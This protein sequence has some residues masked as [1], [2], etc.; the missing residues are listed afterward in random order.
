MQLS[1]QAVE[2][3]VRHP[4]ARVLQLLLAIYA[5]AYVATEHLEV[6]AHGNGSTGIAAHLFPNSYLLHTSILYLPGIFFALACSGIDRS[7]PLKVATFAF[8]TTILHYFLSTGWWELTSGSAIL[9][10]ALTVGPL[11]FLLFLRQ[12]LEETELGTHKAEK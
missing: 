6:G 10:Y 2:D 5:G 1:E 4:V 11:F 7:T 8:T 12:K 3:G 9:V